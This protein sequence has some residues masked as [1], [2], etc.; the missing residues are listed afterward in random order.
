MKR[1]ALLLFVVP[2]VLA[3]RPRAQ[4]PPMSSPPAATTAPGDKSE[5]EEGFSIASDL[6]KR[7]CATCHH[8]DDKGRLT[9]ISYRRTTPEGWE[10]TIKRMVT[11]NNVKLE[12]AE[13]RDIVRYLADHQGLAPDE[14][15]PAAFEVERRQIDFKYAAKDEK[16]K[17][18][19]L[20]EETCIACHSMGRVI[21][22][23]RTKEEWELLV[24]MHR[25]YYWLSDF[26]AFRRTGPTRREPGPDG[27]PP[28][29]RHPMDVAITNLSTTFPLRT[30]EWAAWSATMRPPQLQ[31]RWALSGYQPG[32]GAIFGQVAI[33]PSGAADSGEFTTEITYTIP[34]TGEHVKRAGKAIVYTGYQWRGRSTSS[35]DAEHELR[36]VMFVDRDWRHASGRWFTGAYDEFGI[37][38]Q[39]QRVGADPV[40]TGA[41]QT[42][43]KAG[44]AAQEVALFGANFPARVAATDLNFGPGITVDRVVSATPEQ[45]VVALAAAKDAAVGRRSVFVNGATGDATIAVAN[46]IDYIKVTPQ[47][48]LARVGGAN[49]PKQFQQ[50]EAIAYANG[51]D[52]KPDTK[53]DVELGPVSASWATEEYT[54]TFEDDDKD[55]VGAID[56]KSGLFTPNLDGPNPKRKHNTNNYGDVWVVASYD[57]GPSAAAPRRMLK[58]RAHLLVTVPL[59]IKFDEAEVGR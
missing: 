23:R 34:R 56:P 26:Q 7:K 53:D 44:G 30:P 18:K 14:A 39:L 11:L 46:D 57:A 36:E 22:Q 8:A 59:Y 41:S 3:A 32:K 49:F 42:I 17:D 31:G 13:A 40:I 5:T 48:G 54:A 21:S 50:F 12:P 51:P 6:V 24:A 33:A 45:I 16:D 25:G 38:V 10:Q 29:N 43:V 55:F 4:Q 58:A 47:A 19:Q 52:G 28:D 20:T 35:S 37:D 27:R 15:K 9:R 2:L 1:A